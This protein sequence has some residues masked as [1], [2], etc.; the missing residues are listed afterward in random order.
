MLKSL[1]EDLR[2]FLKETN[3][4]A[5][6]F[7]Q[8]ETLPYDE[9]PP[10]PE[11]VKGRVKCLFSLLRGEEVM[12]ISSIKA[13]MQKV[14]SPLDLEKSIFPLSV[15][16]EIDRDKLVHFLHGGGYSS[17]RVV[18]ERGDFSVRGAIIDIYTPLYGEP[19]RL[20]FDGDRLVSIRRFDAKTQRSF[21]Q[22]V[23]EKAFLLPSRDIWWDPSDHLW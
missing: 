19:L 18:E 11:I 16:E 12:I 21:S 4:I 6:L 20:E 17:A 13:L 14:L 10:H 22:G 7:P 15:G 3:D 1:L 23:M 9:I 8:W 5:F 2:F